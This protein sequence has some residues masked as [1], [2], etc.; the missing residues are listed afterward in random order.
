MVN[1]KRRQG[2]VAKRCISQRLVQRQRRQPSGSTNQ[3]GAGPKCCQ[4]LKILVFFSGAVE[5]CGPGADAAVHKVRVVANEKPQR[6]F[7]H[8]QR[9]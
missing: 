4:R 8:P 3:T 9:R 2:L 5:G 1:Q 6:D 7:G